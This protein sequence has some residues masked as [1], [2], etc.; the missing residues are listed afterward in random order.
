MIPTEDNRFADIPEMQNARMAVE[1]TLF[2]QGRGA[3]GLSDNAK[4]LFTGVQRI[5]YSLGMQTL[6]GLKNTVQK[7]PFHL[8]HYQN[9]AL[10][11][12]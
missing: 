3:S 12:F 9:R 10:Y 1:N 11:P 2:N 4:D 7:L 5:A 8:I 6:T